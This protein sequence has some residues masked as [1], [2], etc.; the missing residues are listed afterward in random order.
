M[1]SF[2]QRDLSTIFSSVKNKEEEAISAKQISFAIAD[3]LH[4]LSILYPAVS[5]KTTLIVPYIKI[6]ISYKEITRLHLNFCE[7]SAAACVI[8]AIPFTKS[9]SVTLRNMP[10]MA[11]A[12]VTAPLMSK[13]GAAAERMP[14]RISPFSMA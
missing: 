1:P 8:S 7:I 2:L 6:N 5:A 13:M 11:M 12:Y 10:V 3:I 4:G 9:S 14:M